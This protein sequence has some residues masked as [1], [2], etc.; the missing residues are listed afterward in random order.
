GFAGTLGAEWCDYLLADETAIPPDTLR[1]YRRNVDLEDSFK[2]GNCGSDDERWVYGENVIF[3]RDTF[4]CCDHKQSSP[5]A[6][7][8][9]S[10]WDEELTERWRM[11]KE[12]FPRLSDD[13][14]IFGNFNQL[15]KI[16]PTT[17]RT[18]LRILARVPNSI[19]WLLRFPDLGEH[20]LLNTAR[21]W[22]GENVAS[23][24]IFTDVA[25]KHLH[26][27]RARI[28]DLV[29]DTAECNAHTT[30]ADVLWSGTPLLTLPRYGYKMCS[31][32]AAS[33]LLGALPKNAEGVQ[34]GREL[35]A[36][37]EEEYEEMAVKLGGSLTYHP[38]PQSSTHRHLPSSSSP[39]SS[40]HLPSV[41]GHVGEGR[42]TGR[43]MELRHLLYH[44]RWTSAL[45]D[46]RRWTRDLEDAFEIA[47][48]RYVD[49]EGGD[50]WLK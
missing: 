21:L 30:A 22:A 44:A 28:C 4:F 25:P 39:S 24:V 41:G 23:R 29:L 7:Q 37:T 35:V 40:R 48:A 12:L 26:I 6:R 20:H 49:G 10:N 2:D 38:A 50:I 9:L 19:L 3:C 45:F 1:P 18:W 31:R 13:T 33:I 32:M 5:E 43:L 15:Y 46:T 11:R 47:W 16:D 14:V 34:A 36:K 27:S 17:F 8:K 42:G